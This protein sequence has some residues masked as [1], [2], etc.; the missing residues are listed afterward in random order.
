MRSAHASLHTE[1]LSWTC[2]AAF[3]PFIDEGYVRFVYGGVEEGKQL[4]NSPVVKS[5][6]LT[7]SAATYEAIMWG[8]ASRKVCLNLL[9]CR[10]VPTVSLVGL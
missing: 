1:C 2:R 9:T 3:K 6:H 8:T 4:C 7:G 5:I 10:L